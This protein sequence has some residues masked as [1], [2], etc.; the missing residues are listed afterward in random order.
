MDITSPFSI[1][2]AIAKV[3]QLD[4]L[5]LVIHNAGIAQKGLVIEND[6]EVDRKIMETNY[7][8]TVAYTKS[9]MPIYLSQGFGM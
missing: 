9:I 4:R 8:G 3:K 1:E 5:D 2:N 6:M 7:F